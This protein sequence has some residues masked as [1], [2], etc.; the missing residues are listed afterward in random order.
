MR[1]ELE[2]LEMTL[3]AHP[4]ALFG[5]LLDWVRA[6]RPVVRSRDLRQHAGQEVYLLGWKVTAKRTTTVDDE[7]MCFVTF[8]DEHGRFEAGFFPEAYERCAREL[9]RGFG[10]FLVKGRVEVEFG[11]AELVASH[12][13]LL[14]GLGRA[15]AAAPPP[16]AVE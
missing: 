1:V 13:K 2:T 4:F 8:S 9:I 5:D 3:D 7:T 12:L 14:L 10:P 6:R 11:A 15:S 16:G